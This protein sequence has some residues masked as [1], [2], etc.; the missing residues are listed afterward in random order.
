LNTTGADVPVSAGSRRLFF[1]YWPPLAIRNE[2]ADLA[3]RLPAPWF[4]VA[5]EDLH[6]TVLFLGEVGDAQATAL[7][8]SMDYLP[9]HRF[10]QPLDSLEAWADGRICCLAGRSD[11]R[12]AALHA[13]LAGRAAEV[14]LKVGSGVIRAHVT[15]ARTPKGLRGR[16][17]DPLA[18]A[19]RLDFPALALTLA[20]STTASE[21]PRYRQ[22]ARWAGTLTRGG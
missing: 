3:Q 1:A 16:V 4:P 15:I 9:L 8:E 6:M 18:G 22:V 5:S 7:C 2:L 14:G 10:E 17:P 19:A 13:A 20:H 11:P 12:L 21:L